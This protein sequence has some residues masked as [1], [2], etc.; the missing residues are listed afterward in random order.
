[1]RNQTLLNMFDKS[2][3][4]EH[5]TVKVLYTGDIIDCFFRKSNDNT[6]EK[7]TMIMYYSADAPVD[8]G[9]LL[10]FRGKTFLTLNKETTENDVYCK[11]AIIR[12]TGKITTHS[13]S[14][15]DLPV[16]SE[17]IN[18][19][20]VTVL[21]HLTVID[22]NIDL[23]TEDNEISRQ[24]RVND[25]FNE[26]GRT[27]KI[28]NLFYV[29]GICRIVCEVNEDITP[30]YHSKLE[31]TPLSAVNVAPNDT[32][33]ISATAFI[34]DSE[35]KKATLIYYSSDS[36]VATIDSEGNIVYLADGEVYFT[37]YWQEQDITEQTA[38]VTVLGAPIDE[39]VSIYVESLE[40]ICYDFP[41]TLNY[42]AM[43]GGVR[44]DSITVS[45]KIENLSVTNNL[46]TYLKK[47]SITDNGDHTIEL[48]VNGS[49]MRGKTFDLVAYNDDY[50]IE[51]IQNI[52]IVSLF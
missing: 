32:E 25:L 31:L 39:D 22:G 4:R 36:N 10:S 23:L 2:M 35:I 24:L 41:E 9:T 49:V 46:N 30:V 29:N 21:T 1:M 14:V 5:K 27:W 50:E 12:T 38:T 40:E 47:I 48:A 43:R 11:S 19:A 37:A 51:N 20:N 45:F 33:S 3:Q 15:L 7:D 18:N 28:S 13:L 17:S 42:Y 26:F 16:Y 8:V 52:K 6:N 34:N 44:D